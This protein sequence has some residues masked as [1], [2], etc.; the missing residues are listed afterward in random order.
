MRLLCDN[1]DDASSSIGAS[2]RVL[3]PT[4]ELP[5]GKDASKA[6]TPTSPKKTPILLAAAFFVAGLILVVGWLVLQPAEVA[7]ITL[8]PRPVEITLSVVG[9]VQ[10]RTTLDVR[11]QNAGQIVELLHDEG[12]VIA[13]GAALA[14]IRSD[15]EAAEVSAMSAREQAAR[16]EVARVQLVLTRT[17]TLATK[18]FASRAAL[19]NARA[20][21]KSAQAALAAAASDRRAASTRLGE[22]T[23]RAP[24]A[25]IVLLR[26]VD[27]GQ[28][29]T[30]ETMLFQLG[31]A[32]AREIDAEVDEAY[33]DDL[34]QGM[35]ARAAPSGSDVTFTARIMEIS[36]RVDPATGGR[37]ITLAPAAGIALP[38]GR[39]VD[40]TIVINVRADALLVPREAIID[41]GRDPR[42][43]VVDEGGTVDERSVTLDS[44]PSLNAIITNGASAGERIVLNPAQTHPSARVRARETAPL[45]QSPGG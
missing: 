10:S 44:W 42:V 41:A 22:F 9:R 7:I 28:V 43:Y 29:V 13:K 23:V 3:A 1:L 45:P 11:S 35:A 18:G 36:P 26:P 20:A 4:R 5:D 16:T 24:M 39:T 38:P 19:D 2:L 21:A 27:N 33:A 37:S 14:V 34:R 15:V 32:D 17:E 31:S 30:P 8:A 12:E 40:V 25:G 6:P